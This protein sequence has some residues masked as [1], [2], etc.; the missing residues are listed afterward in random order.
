MELFDEEKKICM[1]NSFNDRVIN[2]EECNSIMNQTQSVCIVKS[3]KNNSRNNSIELLVENIIRMDKRENLKTLDNQRKNSLL[4]SK[5][6]IKRNQGI[7]QIKTNKH[8]PSLEKKIT[9]RNLLKNNENLRKNFLSLNEKMNVNKIPEKLRLV[10]PVVQNDSKISKM[11]NSNLINQINNNILNTNESKSQTKSR[12]QPNRIESSKTVIKTF[13]K[14]G[15]KNSDSKTPEI[16]KTFCKKNSELSIANLMSTNSNIF[17]NKLF[18]RNDNK[19]DSKSKLTTFKKL[20]DTKEV[21]PFHIMINL[22]N[23]DKYQ[24]KEPLLTHKYTRN[25]RNKFNIQQINSSHIKSTTLV[26]SNPNYQFKTINKLSDKPTSKQTIEISNNMKKEI[27]E[28]IKSRNAIYPQ[29]TKQDSL[30][31]SQ[32]NNIFQ[33]TNK[34]NQ[35]NLISRNLFLQHTKSNNKNYKKNKTPDF[36]K[37]EKFD[38]NSKSPIK[39]EEILKIKKRISDKY[40]SKLL[41]ENKALK[42]KNIFD[43]TAQSSQPNSARIDIIVEKRKNKI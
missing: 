32:I 36:I 2:T 26:L 12:N 30:K 3:T 17:N 5:P 37:T 8:Q 1:L 41:S 25:L 39:K 35:N 4:V 22:D 15:Q 16:Q 21:S 20:N 14:D 43:Y 9:E 7:L 31:I 11:K 18:S 34:L 13:D 10:E 24:K 40:T 29:F 6:S 27:P 28:N 42:N 38:F 33:S 19:S 23:S